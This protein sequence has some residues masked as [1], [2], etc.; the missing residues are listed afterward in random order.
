MEPSAAQL[1]AA[2]LALINTLI[3]RQGHPRGLLRLV[4]AFSFARWGLEGYVIAESNKLTG[5]CTAVAAGG[6]VGARTLVPAG[7]HA[8]VSVPMCTSLHLGARH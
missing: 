4:Q 8:G 5:K 2:V 6:R 7:A 3:A 1:S